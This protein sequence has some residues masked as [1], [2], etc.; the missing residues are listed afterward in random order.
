MNSHARISISVPS[1]HRRRRRTPQCYRHFCPQ[2]SPEK[3][4]IPNS[5]SLL[6]LTPVVYLNSV[7]CDVI[8]VYIMDG[9]HGRS[10]LNASGACCRGWV[11][12]PM[13]MG[14]LP[15]IKC[16]HFKLFPVSKTTRIKG[17]KIEIIVREPGLATNSIFFCFLFV[18]KSLICLESKSMTSCW[19]NAILLHSSQQLPCLRLGPLKGFL[20]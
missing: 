13:G 3:S 18:K 9:P 17:Q 16:Q 5:A 6:L 7:T 2:S 19:G 11:N 4:V 12:E 14:C 10:R 20:S 1:R 8:V 15:R